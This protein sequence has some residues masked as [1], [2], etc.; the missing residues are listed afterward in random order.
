VYRIQ[1]V[2][3]ANKGARGE[4]KANMYFTIL[5]KHKNTSTAE[6]KQSLLQQYNCGKVK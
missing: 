5:S 1:V 4:K 2:S 6:E 3:Q